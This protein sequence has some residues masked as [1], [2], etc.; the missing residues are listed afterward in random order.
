MKE[1]DTWLQKNATKFVPAIYPPSWVSNSKK[2]S[3][4]L[5]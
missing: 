4:K 1:S 3:V 5:V 2:G